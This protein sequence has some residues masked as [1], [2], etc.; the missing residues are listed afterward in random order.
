MFKKISL[1]LL[2]AFCMA[3]GAAIA[4][5]P[6]DRHNTQKEAME[7]V[8]TVKEGIQSTDYPKVMWGLQQLSSVSFDKV[9]SPLSLVYDLV[10]ALENGRE[11][12]MVL[13]LKKMFT[14]QLRKVVQEIF[15]T[16][17]K[18]EKYVTEDTKKNTLAKLTA[19]K[20]LLDPHKEP[21]ISILQ[22]FE[23][24][25]NIIS[26]L[27][28]NKSKKA[29]AASFVY[30]AI[31]VA[32]NKDVN[33]LQALGEMVFDKLKTAYQKSLAEQIAAV[34]A[35]GNMAIQTGDKKAFEELLTIYKNTKFGEVQYEAIRIFGKIAR[36]HYG[37]NKDNKMF[38]DVAYP[39]FS[40]L[41][42][43]IKPTPL[44]ELKTNQSLPRVAA[45]EELILLENRLDKSSQKTL[46]TYLGQ[47]KATEQEKLKSKKRIIGGKIGVTKNT[48]KV[49]CALDNSGEVFR[50]AFIEGE[51]NWT[52][53]EDT[54]QKLEKILKKQEEI[55][56]I[57]VKS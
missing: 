44:F 51:A 15:L 2:S 25:I 36:L 31:Q 39:C 8:Q 49:L 30:N 14:L 57:L 34:E 26:L 24:C 35:L 56:G 33:A 10:A 7:Y 55:L 5:I 20:N 16:I 43:A 54:N 28:E 45:T 48:T 29:E 21:C 19:F 27:D 6:S 42:E 32:V 46:A 52:A 23:Y 3:P 4:G 22:D 41:I 13:E 12:F 9:T 53:P 50:L 11:D 37:G 40:I 1:A 47:L 38:D 17:V 18:A